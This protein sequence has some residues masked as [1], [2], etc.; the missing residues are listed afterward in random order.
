[1]ATKSHTEAPSGAKPAFPP[2][3]KE[4][5]A[6]QLVSFAIA[7]VLLYIIVSKVALPRMG[8]VLATEG[9]YL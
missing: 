7:F 6:S 1:M 3:A 4:T 9:R 5:F 8:N 2:F